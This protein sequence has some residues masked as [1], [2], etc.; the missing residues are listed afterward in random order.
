MIPQYKYDKD[1]K[2]HAENG[3]NPDR[4][5]PSEGVVRSGQ[6]RF[7]TDPADHSYKRCEAHQGGKTIMG[8]PVGNEF[9]AAN[10]RKSR[11]GSDHQPGHLSRR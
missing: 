2:N 10:K 1:Q 3:Q 11:T 9:E 8:K 5:P 6:W 7:P 4:T